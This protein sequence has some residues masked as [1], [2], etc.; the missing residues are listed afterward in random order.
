MNK[1]NFSFTCKLKELTEKMSN[2]TLFIDYIEYFHISESMVD[3]NDT[4][5]CDNKIY[6]VFFR[7]K[8]SVLRNSRLA[9]LFI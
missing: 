4:L 9:H 8:Q 6:D 5:K 7:V 1:F 3:E 2:F